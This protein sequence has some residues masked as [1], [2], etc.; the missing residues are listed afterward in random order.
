M[1]DFAAYDATP[2]EP[3]G[4]PPPAQA[5][6]PGVPWI[7]HP[8]AYCQSTSLQMIAEW[9]SGSARP[10]GFYNWLMGFTYGAG[11]LRGSL[12]FLP[13]GD[14]EAGLRFAAPS[15]GLC[16]RYL[17]SDDALAY[18]QA[19]KSALAEGVPIRIM[20]DSATLKG[21]SDYFSPHSI[22]VVG[23]RR[24][25]AEVYETRTE[26][27][28]EH[29]AR[30]DELPWELLLSAARRVS[31]VYRYPW[32]YQ[33]TRFEP[34]EPIPLDGRAVC[35]R[36]AASLLGAEGPFA[37]TGALAASSLARALQERGADASS[38]FGDL[39]VFFEYGAYTRADN[40][41]YL[42]DEHGDRPPLRE[43][44]QLLRS[45][46]RGYETMVEAIEAN[47][48]RA[49]DV[50]VGELERLAGLERSAG[51]CLAQAAGCPTGC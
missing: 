11:H 14:P 3:M 37:V 6:V 50:L 10:L 13:Y 38:A 40:A 34:C 48:D 1:S 12:L 25:V 5:A 15:L 33:F 35:G 49:R 44:A 27:K 4:T 21:R 39:K 19:A 17:V 28:R 22:V 36:N 43:A 47:Q 20:V 16:H 9:R 29:G 31:A 8:R 30:G 46:A 23:Y 41:T 51:L 2:I 45:A 24:D 32:T 42:D 7:A 26:E 18:V